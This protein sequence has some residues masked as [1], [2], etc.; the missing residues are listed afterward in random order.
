MNPPATF[1]W[2]DYETFGAEPMFD[3]PAQ[4]AAQRTCMNLEPIG[5]PVSW[6]CAPADDVLPHPAACLITGITPQYARREGLVETAFAEQILAVMM[7][8]GTCAAGFNS[9][10][11]DDVITRNLLYRNFR[12]PYERE[13][14]NGNS[15]WDLIDL[16]RMCYALRPEGINWPLRQATDDGPAAVSAPSFKLE[17][18]ARANGIDHR[19]AH[20]AL[21]DVRTTIALARLIKTSQ[22]KLFEWAL[23]LRKQKTAMA[24]LNPVTATPVLHTSSRI[25]AVR[26]CTSLVL[27]LAVLPKRPKSVVVFDL[28]ADPA[29]LIQ[30]APETIAD[31]VFT[32]VADLPEGIRRL[33]LKTIHSNHVPMLAPAATLREVDT[34]RIQLDPARCQAHAVLL[35]QALP[36]VRRKVLEVFSHP[37]EDDGEGSGTDPDQMLY[38]GGFFTP[39]D[40]HLMRKV[41]AVSP[42]E[43]AG[44][45]WGFSDRRLPLMLFRF[46]ARNYPETLTSQERETW[47]QDRSRRLVAAADARQLSFAS[48]RSV[49][50][51]LRRSRAGDERDLGILDQ[52]EAWVQQTGLERLWQEQEPASG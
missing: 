23:G 22:P 5:E 6:Y 39:G 44:H 13:Y 2:H 17:D 18:L 45:A 28:M 35:Q 41:L 51:E 31:L 42:P 20:E 29:P 40:R 38:S 3:R 48:F 52:L 43:L 15:R 36:E 4:F 19:G 21:A 49:I 12:D 25:A 1:L 30:E 14:L 33:P 26:G 34:D 50:S 46:R 37:Y 8:P 10:R 7:Q 11:F 16:A 24:L 47:D 9:L 27:P 32:P